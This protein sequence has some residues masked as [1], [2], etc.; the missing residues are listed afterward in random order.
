MGLFDRFK[1]FRGKRACKKGKHD[2]EYIGVQPGRQGHRVISKCSRCERRF[3]NPLTRHQARM[4]KTIRSDR[5]RALRKARRRAWKGIYTT[6]QMLAQ[7]RS[8][9]IAF[10]RIDQRLREQGINPKGEQ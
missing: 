8:L 3:I 9:R 2:L 7:R 6:D 5:F 4:L 10:A 1:K